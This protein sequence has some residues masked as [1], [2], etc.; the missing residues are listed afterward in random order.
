MAEKEHSVDDF[1]KPSSELENHL[2]RR[3][4]GGLADPPSERFL[5]KGLAVTVSRQH[6]HGRQLLLRRDISRP[7]GVNGRA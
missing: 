5:A 2:N 7:G 4:K 3:G 6:Q 1:R